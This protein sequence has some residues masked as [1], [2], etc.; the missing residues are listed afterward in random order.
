MIHSINGFQLNNIAIQPANSSSCDDNY[1]GII[2]YDGNSFVGY[3]G[4]NLFGLQ[5]NAKQSHNNSQKRV[6]IDYNSF[7]PTQNPRKII[8]LLESPHTEEFF[9]KFRNGV[10]SG[11]ALGISGGVFDKH[12]IDVFNY[13]K[14]IL[15]LALHLTNQSEIFEMYF[16]NAIQYQCSLGPPLKP[17]IRDFVF[18]ALWNQHPNS[19]KDDL[20]ER[21]NIIQPDLIINACTKELQNSCCNANA[22][23]PGLHGFQYSFLAASSHIKAWNNSTIIQ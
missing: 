21:L 6:K 15:R 18:Y 23:T 13:N 12:C 4:S 8:I 22:I 3:N 1:I 19:F 7:S 9:P 10:S 14:N 5:R 11:P 2:E 20:I 17:T 16:V